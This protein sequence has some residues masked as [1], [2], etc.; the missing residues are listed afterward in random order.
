MHLISKAYY[1]K[2]DDKLRHLII[3]E[4]MQTNHSPYL[5]CVTDQSDFDLYIFFGLLQ[6]ECTCMLPIF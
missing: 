4:Q 3:C 5:T 6:S 1:A 2:K